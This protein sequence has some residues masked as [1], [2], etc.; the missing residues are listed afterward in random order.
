[1]NRSDS[2]LDL[3]PGCDDLKVHEV[4]EGCVCL[5]EITAESFDWLMG[6]ESN[7]FG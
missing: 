1:M 7:Y 4:N 3:G 2:E 5:R 6:G